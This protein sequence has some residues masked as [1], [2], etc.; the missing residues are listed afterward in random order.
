M[1]VLTQVLP[2]AINTHFDGLA[3][4]IVDEINGTKIKKLSDVAEALKKDVEK[5]VVIKLLGDGR[6]IVLEKEK[7]AEAQNRINRQYNVREDA[8]IE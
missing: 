3:G 2:D 5:F 8:F 1:V 4:R 6:P 7:I